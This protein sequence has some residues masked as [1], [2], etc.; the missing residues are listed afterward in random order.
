MGNYVILGNTFLFSI[1]SAKYGISH[2]SRLQKEFSAG[3]PAEPS[4]LFNT[5]LSYLLPEVIQAK[6]PVDECFNFL[7]FL[8]VIGFSRFWHITYITVVISMNAQ[9]MILP[10]MFLELRHGGVQNDIPNNCTQMIFISM[11]IFPQARLI[12]SSSCFGIW[13]RSINN[14]DVCCEFNTRTAEIFVF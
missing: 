10:E 11:V 5:S 6:H 9:E 4:K 1:S 2:L 7:I 12:K 14:S 13:N 3:Y 8:S